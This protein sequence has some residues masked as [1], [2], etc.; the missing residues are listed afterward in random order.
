MSYCDMTSHP[1]NH[2]GQSAQS[3][4]R[5][6]RPGDPA[7]LSWGLSALVIGVLSALSWAVMIALA[8]ALWWGF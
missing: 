7:P 1:R 4:E 8:L 3:E 6:V 2:M 5:G